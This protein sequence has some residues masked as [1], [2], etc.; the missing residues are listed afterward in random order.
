MGAST[1][2]MQCTGVCCVGLV[3]LTDAGWKALV[4]GD[5]PGQALNSIDWL[6]SFSPIT[7]SGHTQA[8]E[9]PTG[10]GHLGLSLPQEGL[11]H[12]GK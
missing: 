11:G 4:H 9:M 7:P 1:M 6:I 3:S 12:G 8:P 10:Q 5:S 2:Q